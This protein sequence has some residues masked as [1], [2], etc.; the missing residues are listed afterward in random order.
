M[1]KALE[2]RVAQPVDAERVL[3]RVDSLQDE[4][5]QAVS[6]AVQ[7]ESVN[8]K[9]PGQVYEDIVGGEG[10]VSRFVSQ[11]YEAV[12]CEVDLFAIEPG[13]ENCVGAWKGTGG[14]RSLIYN[15]H[16]DV[17]P[18]GDLAGWQSGSPWSG[19]IDGDRI[20][21]RGS[22]D[23][24]GGVVAQAFAARAIRE[25]G[26]DLKGDLILE[27]VVGEETMDHE[28]GTTATLRRGYVADAAVI[29]EPSGSLMQPLAIAPVTAGLLGMSLTVRG[30]RTHA[31]NRAQV[32]RTGGSGDEVGV[33]AVEKGIFVINAIRRLEEEWGQT[34]RHRLF[35][36]GHFT[37]NP[38]A[39]VAGTEGTFLYPAM[40][41]DYLTVTYAVFHH[42]DED[43]EN[44]KR[45][46]EGQIHRAA[47]LDP[48]LREHPPE[49]EWMFRWPASVVSPSHPVCEAVA[50]AHEQGAE[51]TR[52][53]GEPALRGFAAV[54]DASFFNAA[55][56]PAISYG[57]G[58]GR[59]AHADD[60]YVLID[61]LV[62]ATRTYALLAMG[63]CG[64]E[65]ASRS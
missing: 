27:A 45:E 56:V 40:V 61:E 1:S 23:M 16:V 54:D 15:G 21:G 64:Y 3:E 22:T 35:E 38:G 20:W 17:V 65:K 5:V 49:V 28:C 12:G 57:P 59:V 42:P 50:A 63:W 11:L 29:A 2:A 46:I 33:D 47:Q 53:A 43:S 39:L 32:I 48:W 8:P 58:N 31:G 7:I 9:Y 30:K 13:R 52:F 26:F 34:K 44:V 4:L 55:G 6:E 18:P 19:K 24:K 41:A 51:G 10:Q 60:E 62:T 37:I 36:P 25:A 14:G